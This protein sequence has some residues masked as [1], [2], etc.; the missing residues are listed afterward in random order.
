MGNDKIL[1][2]L[3]RVDEETDTVYEGYL[4]EVE[5]T[6]EAEQLYVNYGRKGGHIAVLALDDNIDCIYNDDG[7]LLYFPF[8]RLYCDKDSGHPLDFIAGNAM[9]V[10][11]NSAGEF[12]SIKP[13]DI[14][15]IEKCLLAFGNIKKYEEES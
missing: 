11:H 4:C 10:R 12:T 15:V 1:A 13:E 9:C 6:L 8:N 5:N 14:L 7:K 3:M 2:Y